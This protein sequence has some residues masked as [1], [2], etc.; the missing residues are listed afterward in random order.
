M[1]HCWQSHDAAH[2]YTFLNKDINKQIC[3]R[4]VNRHTK[5]KYII[6]QFHTMSHEEAVFGV[7]KSYDNSN[8]HTRLQGPVKI[9]RKRAGASFLSL[10]L[11]VFLGYLSRKLKPR[12]IHVTAG[13]NRKSISA[14][15]PRYAPGMPGP[16]DAERTNDWCISTGHLSY[17]GCLH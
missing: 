8:W 1:P 10:R 2:T 6:C 7:L 12:H 16:K 3:K 13:T 4:K 5:Q 9:F 14:Y 15:K 17:L 11:A